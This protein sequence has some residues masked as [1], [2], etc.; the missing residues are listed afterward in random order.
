[1]KISN[2]IKLI[3][4]F[5]VIIIISFFFIPELVNIYK[6]KQKLAKTK[7]II[8]NYESQKIKFRQNLKESK[9]ISDILQQNIDE[10]IKKL[11]EVI[12][13][14]SLYGEAINEEKSDGYLTE[15][16]NDE[17][18]A[19]IKLYENNIISSNNIINNLRIFFQNN[20]LEDYYNNISNILLISTIIKNRI[21]INFI[22]DKIV[23]PFYSES[24]ENN[25]NIINKKYIL[26]EPCFKASIDTN[27]PYEFH[28]KC[29]NV[30]DTIMLIKTN[31]TRFG[32]IT[33]LPW[34]KIISKENEFNNTKTR[35]FNLDNQKIFMYDKNQKVSRYV[36]PIR[37]ENYYFANFGYNDV[38]LGFIPWEST[39]SF[40]Q[41][42][43]KSND[44][45][46]DFND[47]LNQ[48][49]ENYYSYNNQI[50]FEYLDIEVY[51]IILINETK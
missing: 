12:K 43:L 38:Y 32:I 2:E 7:I 42:F 18:Y 16:R 13:L 34:G 28:K 6:I 33:D 31:K 20:T 14:N 29:K 8:D 27:N 10:E 35:L 17:M 46:I 22:Y 40:P 5:L 48:K 19:I 36:A 4:I 21:D 24:K 41:Q 3:V 47:L 30:G 9:N 26:K 11:K 25:N 51:P 49:N 1:M 50:N 45:D 44:T 23:K 15:R 39:S 37:A